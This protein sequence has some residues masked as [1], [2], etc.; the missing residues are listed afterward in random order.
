MDKSIQQLVTEILTDELLVVKNRINPNAAL[1]YDLGLDSLDVVIFCELLESKLSLK[2]G[3][4]EL[5]TDDYVN[6]TVKDLFTVAEKAKKQAELEQQ[7][8]MLRY[9]QKQMKT[10]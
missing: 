3:T 1:F 2:D 9:R 4:V 6:L 8:R 7:K 10:K 5:P